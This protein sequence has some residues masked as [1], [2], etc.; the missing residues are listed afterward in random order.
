LSSLPLSVN[1][2]V[3]LTHL[4]LYFDAYKPYTIANKGPPMAIADIQLKGDG[5]TTNTAIIVI[6]KAIV[7]I[8]NQDMP[9][10]LSM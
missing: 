1:R 4:D 8:H 2:Y 9:L 3:N 5:N 6:I 10:L 7:V